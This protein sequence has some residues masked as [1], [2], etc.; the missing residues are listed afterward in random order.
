MSRI[1]GDVENENLAGV[2]AR[3]PQRPAVVGE[4]G[5]VGLVPSG[6]RRT[7]DDLPVA[8]GFGIYVNGDEAVVAVAHPLDSQR[9]DVDV[10]F[11][12]GHLREER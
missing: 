6:N 4:A 1:G 8:F 10:V 9:P 12:P 2:E 7:V 3:G 5:V 11:L